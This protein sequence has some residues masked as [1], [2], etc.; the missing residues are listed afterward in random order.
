MLGL[1]APASAQ[2]PDTI[3]PAEARACVDMGTHYVTTN[4]Q[5]LFIG[6]GTKFKSGPGG[7]V[8]AAVQGSLTATAS[9]TI[10][11][12]ATLSPVIASFNATFGVTG[13]ASASVSS[14]WTYDHDV[15]A[16]K[17]GTLQFGNWGWRSTL[18]KYVVDAS[19]NVTSDVTGT[20]NQLPSVDTWGYMY[21]ES[22][23]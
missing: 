16:G 14:T 15:P 23:S 20:L 1:A 10:S 11:G 4:K 12:G 13:T 6:L 21:T 19:C 7:T 2:T 5:D 18:R 17:F 8:H 22:T 9:A 3:F